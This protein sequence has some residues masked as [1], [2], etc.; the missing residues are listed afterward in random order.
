[1]IFINVGGEMYSQNVTEF[2]PRMAESLLQ[3]MLSSIPVIMLTGPRAIGKSTL[4]R[5]FA[6]SELDLDNPQTVSYLEKSNYAELETLKNPLLI[7]E[8][9]KSPGIL[10]KIKRLVDENPA[11]GQFLITGSASSVA[12]EEIWPLVGRAAFLPIRPMTQNELRSTEGEIF[13]AIRTAASIGN[14]RLDFKRDDFIDA[15]AESGYPSMIGV[16]F[17]LPIYSHLLKSIADNAIASE[18]KSLGL[19]SNSDKL[20][21]YM[22]A[23]A[24]TSATL[25]SETTVFEMAGVSRPSA[26]KYDLALRKLGL[27]YE[28]PAF[29][30]NDF[31]RLKKRSKTMF[32]DTAMLASINGWH[33]QMVETDSQKL[34][35]LAENFLA[36]QLI[37]FADQEMAKLS[38]LRSANGEREIDFILEMPEGI[39][40]IEVKASEK[41]SVSDARHIVWFAS[42]T[43]K[44][45]FGMVVYLGKEQF[46]LAEN[47]FAVPMAALWQ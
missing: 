42:Q 4:A 22:L 6:N 5:R 7:D 12:D 10:S 16:D 37:A 13:Q 2:R 11:K 36:Q 39:I 32:S 31:S 43:T 47:V 20:A 27:T 44:F 9:Q 1:M 19:S 18:A 34:A 29:S 21:D 45:Q 40:P 15:V 33:K 30:N 14:K 35:V 8:W 17:H 25:A 28:V 26:I 24:A 23:V 46:Q 3:Q 41:V 38:Y